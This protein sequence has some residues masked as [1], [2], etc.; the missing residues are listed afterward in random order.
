MKQNGFSCGSVVKN[1]ST[2]AG[3]TGL[4]P[5]LGKSPGEGNGNPLQYSCLENP[6]DSDALKATVHRVAE[7]DTTEQLR[8]HTHRQNKCQDT[9]SKKKS[10]DR[11]SM[12]N[13]QCWKR[14]FTQKYTIHIW[15]DIQ[16]TEDGCSMISVHME[17]H[18]QDRI[19]RN[20]VELL[21]RKQAKLAKTGFINPGFKV[22]WN[23]PN[24]IQKI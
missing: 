21:T 11:K 10:R 12:Y 23:Y 8:T 1:L 18:F 5:G 24:D 3:D 13:V 7:L 4:I 16:E 15:K 14:S 19:T 2:K 22:S 9:K 6:M 20:S 17:F